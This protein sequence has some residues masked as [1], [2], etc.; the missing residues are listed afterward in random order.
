M[1][2]CWKIYEFNTFSYCLTD[3]AKLILPSNETDLRYVNSSDQWN[4]VP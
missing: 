3:S 4:F 2:L 1:V